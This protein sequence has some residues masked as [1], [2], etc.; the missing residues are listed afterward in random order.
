MV[1]SIEQSRG[2]RGLASLPAQAAYALPQ[3]R[4]ARLGLRPLLP[5]HQPPGRPLSAYAGHVRVAA[6]A[7]VALG[8]DEDVV[9]GRQEMAS[10]ERAAVRRR[11]AVA[12]RANRPPARRGDAHLANRSPGTRAA[13]RMSWAPRRRCVA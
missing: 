10:A 8:R 9:G 6:P 2:E 5:R 12:R 1:W 3:R 7:R 4:R 13:T 11:L